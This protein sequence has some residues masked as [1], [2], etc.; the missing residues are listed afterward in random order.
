MTATVATIAATAAAVHAAADEA[1]LALVAARKQCAGA[2]RELLDLVNAV[3]TNQEN[4]ARL[5][6][7]TLWV[8]ERRRQG[9]WRPP[10]AA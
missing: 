2:E 3:I 10:A 9:P 8:L 7:M 4:T 6:V 5:A 1:R